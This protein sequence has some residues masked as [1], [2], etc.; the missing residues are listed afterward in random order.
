M[1]TNYYFQTNVCFYWNGCNCPLLY[2]LNLCTA[3]DPLLGDYRGW[4][5]PFGAML[6]QKGPSGG[7]C[8]HARAY[9]FIPCCLLQAACGCVLGS[10]MQLFCCLFYDSELVEDQKLGHSTSSSGL[11]VGPRAGL[12]MRASQGAVVLGPRLYISS[13]R[14]C[15]A[16]VL[17]SQPSYGGQ[18]GTPS[19]TPNL[20]CTE[21]YDTRL[22]P[23]DPSGPL[24]CCFCSCGPRN[25]CGPPHESMVSERVR[26]MQT[27]ELQREASIRTQLKDRGRERME[28]LQQRQQTQVTDEKRRDEEWRSMQTR[29]EQALLIAKETH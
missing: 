18:R 17:C 22:L 28:R 20:L 21:W 10:A 24:D 16:A 25:C 23:D 1:A 26:K 12:Y 8:R 13:C 11:M 14:E 3:G 9:P 7:F 15:V 4:I 27:R 2:C 19:N 5:F 6:S 29:A